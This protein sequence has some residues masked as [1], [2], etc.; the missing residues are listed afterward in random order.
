M[1]PQSPYKRYRVF[2]STWETFERIIE[3]CDETEAENLAL[4]LLDCDGTAWFAL[5]GSGID[6]LIGV[7]IAPTRPRLSPAP[8]FQGRG[9]FRFSS[10]STGPATADRRNNRRDRPDT[11]ARPG[12]RLGGAPAALA[13]RAAAASAARS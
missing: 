8:R 5:S 10:A 4:Q 12:A 6:N 11:S 13:A 2:F 9:A 7:E 1:T 3:A